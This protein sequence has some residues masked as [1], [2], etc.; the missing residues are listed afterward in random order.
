MSEINVRLA[1]VEDLKELLDMAIK[2][3]KA[4]PYAQ[5]DELVDTD[6]VNTIRN[7]LILQSMGKAVILVSTDTDNKATGM[8]AAMASKAMWSENLIATEM[9]WW[10]SEDERKSGVGKKLIE[11]YEYWAKMVNA[12]LISL[13]TLKDLDPEVKLEVFYDKEGY[14]KAEQ[15]F[16]KKVN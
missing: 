7:T 3:F 14:V 8:L 9:A 2:F 5:L 15:A 12:K 11:G 16:V 1:S 6:I 10:V 4:S 13:S